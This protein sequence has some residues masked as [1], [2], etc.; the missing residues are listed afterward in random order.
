MRIA[1]KS[2]WYEITIVI[3]TRGAAERPI[4]RSSRT[5]S[6]SAYAINERGE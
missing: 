3:L 2:N 1:M 5:Y 6:V 4:S